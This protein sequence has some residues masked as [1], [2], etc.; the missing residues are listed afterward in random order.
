MAG[1]LLQAAFK[2]HGYRNFDRNPR[3]AA[4][5]KDCQTEQRGKGETRNLPSAA[6]IAAA[7]ARNQ[8][9]FATDENR[10]T[11][12]RQNR[13]CL[14]CVHRFSSVAK[15]LVLKTADLRVSTE[16]A[17]RSGFVFFCIASRLS[18]LCSKI[19]SYPKGAAMKSCD[20][21]REC[22]LTAKTRR[23]EEM[24]K[25]KRGN[26]GLRSLR[27]IWSRFVISAHDEPFGESS[28]LHRRGRERKVACDFAIHSR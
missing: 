23:R 4:L 2:I 15:I 14:I 25:R 19:L 17:E 13:N 28:G 22:F 3:Y 18:R 20:L 10:W 24:Q 1:S 6:E 5:S 7:P 9:I 12:I 21:S 26:P 8:R 11:Q 16:T 27:E